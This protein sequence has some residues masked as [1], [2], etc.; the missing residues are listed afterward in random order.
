[1]EV[2]LKLW[3]AIFLYSLPRKKASDEGR[4]CVRRGTFPEAAWRLALSKRTPV[5]NPFAELLS[6]Y[7]TWKPPWTHRRVLGPLREAGIGGIDTY[8]G[9]AGQWGNSLPVQ[10]YFLGGR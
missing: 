7:S 9:G 3:V 6:S 1:M 2:Q 10:L 5:R 8:L 4:A